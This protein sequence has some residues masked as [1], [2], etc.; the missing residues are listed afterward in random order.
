VFPNQLLSRYSQQSPVLPN[1]GAQPEPPEVFNVNVQA[2][3]NV[4]D[5][6]ALAESGA[7]LQNRNLNKA[8][9]RGDRRASASLDRTFGNDFVAIDANPQATLS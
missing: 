6:Q 5:T 3:V 4:V 1:I 7:G 2:L 8:D 9:R